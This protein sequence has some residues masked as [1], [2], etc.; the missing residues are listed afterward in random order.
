MELESR[1]DFEHVRRRWRAFWD[2]EAL[3]R[4][5]MQIVVPKCGCEVVERPYPVRPDRDI[6]P[7]IDQVLAWEASHDFLG[8]AVPFF[9]L[10]FGP[11][12]FA[13]LLGS[14][15]RYHE[16]YSGTG[17][18]LPFVEDWDDAEIRFRRESFYWER[19]LEF[20]AAMRRRCDGRVLVGSPVLSA[21]L[22]ALSAV[23]GPQRLLEDLVER[24][25]QV[26]RACE[27]VRAAYDEVVEV[28]SAALGWDEMGSVNWLGMYHGGRVNTIQSDISCM[29]SPAMFR[30]FELPNLRH[31]AGHF[32][33]VAYHLDGP[34]GVDSL[35]ERIEQ[36]IGGDAHG[37]AVDLEH[38]VPFSALA[39]ASS[40]RPGR[41]AVS[42]GRAWRRGPASAGDS[43]GS[44]RS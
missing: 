26:H 27:A 41:R 18:A 20:I 16:T 5:L 35:L 8:E 32:D 25:E 2:G 13:A 15:M 10:E 28:G 42:A 21:G 22:D 14:E 43:T 9:T 3:D 1:S 30:Q 34:F 39:G 36:A 29:I 38:R 33:A 6:E 11:E 17:W 19:T 4:P 24:P 23:R 44:R 12:H 7:V 31:Q 37:V 40:R